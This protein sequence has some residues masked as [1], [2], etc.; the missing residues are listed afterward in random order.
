MNAPRN[1][2]QSRSPLYPACI[3]RY[4][5]Y[6]PGGQLQHTGKFNIGNDAERRNFGIR[7][8]KALVDGYRVETQREYPP[9]AV[10]R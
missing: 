4:K 1:N 2:S 3:I 6:T 7:C 5:V 9:H 8:N 10:V